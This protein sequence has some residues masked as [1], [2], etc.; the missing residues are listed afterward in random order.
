MILG[1]VGTGMMMG[2]TAAMMTWAGGH[3]PVM[4]VLTYSVIGSLGT[5]FLAAV[6]DLLKTDTDPSRS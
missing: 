2:L 4:V 5:V 1:S 3:S 6:G